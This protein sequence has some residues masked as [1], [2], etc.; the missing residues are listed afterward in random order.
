M[1]E[2]ENQFGF[3]GTE[4]LVLDGCVDVCGG[5]ELDG[6]GSSVSLKG[7]PELYYHTV[8]GFVYV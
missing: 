8:V 6:I 7:P 5:G 3:K 4:K 2:G 1:Q